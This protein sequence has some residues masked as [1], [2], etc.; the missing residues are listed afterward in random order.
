VVPEREALRRRAADAAAELAGAELRL[1]H[2]AAAVDAAQRC[3][4]IDEYCDAGWRALMDGFTQ[5]GD[6]A[7][8]ARARRDYDGVLATLAV[9]EDDEPL[10]SVSV[11]RGRTAPPLRSLPPVPVARRSP[12]G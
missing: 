5:L 11:I 3:V 9:P 4:R 12:S 1:G 8:A 2:A 6:V 7:A 10:A